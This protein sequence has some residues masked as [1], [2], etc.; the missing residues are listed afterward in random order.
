MASPTQDTAEKVKL[1]S[2]Q[3]WT[4]A[5]VDTLRD[6]RKNPLDMKYAAIL[7]FF[8]LAPL[9]QKKEKKAP[10]NKLAPTLGFNHAKDTPPMIDTDALSE[11]NDLKKRLPGNEFVNDKRAMHEASLMHEFV[12]GFKDSKECAGI[13]FFMRPER[14]P[15]FAVQIT[16]DGHDRPSAEQTWTWI[17]VDM[18][19]KGIGG[20]GNQSSGKLTARDVCLTVWEDVDPNH[21]KKPGGKIEN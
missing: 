17:L 4:F 18:K 7:M 13:K 6:E 14:K 15:D 20:L 11:E 2:L 16:V 5:H 9:A 8:A 21:F 1:G 10:E 3:G 19:N 12:E